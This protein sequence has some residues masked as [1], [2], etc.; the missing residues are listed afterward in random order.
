[1]K[2]TPGRDRT[3]HGGCVYRDRTEQKVAGNIQLYIGPVEPGRTY[4]DRKDGEGVRGG[5]GEG[6]QTLPVL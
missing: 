6:R 2:I 4:Q 3:E 5:G 1:M